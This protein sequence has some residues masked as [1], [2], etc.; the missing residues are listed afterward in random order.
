MRAKAAFAALALLFPVVFAGPAGAASPPVEGQQASA[1]SRVAQITIEGFEEML[2]VSVE[3]KGGIKTE[4]GDTLRVELRDEAKVLFFTRPGHR[5][6][7]G[8]VEVRIVEEENGPGVDTAGWW[9]GDGQAFEAWFRVF[10]RRNERLSR[11]WQMEA[12]PF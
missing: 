10:K 1:D 3:D 4:E 8:V 2:T 9:A 5:A 11:Q 7:P 12:G 6:H